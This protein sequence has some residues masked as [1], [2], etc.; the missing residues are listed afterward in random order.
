MNRNLA[1][2]TDEDARQADEHELPAAESLDEERAEDIA[3]E[4]RS[5][6]L[7]VSETYSGLTRG[8]R[9]T[10]QPGKCFD[11][12]LQHPKRRKQQRPEARHAE[13]DVEDDTVV[14]DAACCQ[15]N[16]GWIGAGVLEHSHEDSGELV[17]PHKHES[18]KCSSSIRWCFEDLPS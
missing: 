15:I 16:S 14:C 10:S 1:N 11:E 5:G 6:V 17:I 9:N 13:L 2:K 4:R 18:H 12:N 3:W 8:K 7:S